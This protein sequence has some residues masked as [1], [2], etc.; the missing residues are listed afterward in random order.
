MFVIDTLSIVEPCA[1]MRCVRLLFSSLFFVCHQDSRLSIDSFFFLHQK[2]D[3]HRIAF[4][5]IGWG[6]LSFTVCVEEISENDVILNVINKRSKC[7]VCCFC[8]TCFVQQTSQYSPKSLH[9]CVASNFNTPILHRIFSAQ[10]EQSSCLSLR[11]EIREKKKT[12]KQ[13]KRF[14]KSEKSSALFGAVRDDAT[15]MTSISTLLMA[16]L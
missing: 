13:E 14:S 4:N 10:I 2:I 5:F 12:D 16:A 8:H 7:V 6:E 9:T 15:A 3:D 1:A 11:R